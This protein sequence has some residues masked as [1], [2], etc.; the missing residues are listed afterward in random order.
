MSDLLSATKF[1]FDRGIKEI[2]LD[3]LKQTEDNIAGDPANR[4][5]ID[6]IN[7]SN[8][9][10]SH[11][12]ARSWLPGVEAAEMKATLLSGEQDKIKKLMVQAGVI[13]NSEVEYFEFHIDPNPK[14]L[15]PP[16]AAFLGYMVEEGRSDTV[17][18]SI[19]N[20]PYPQK[21]ESDWGLTEEQLRSWLATSPE[22]APWEP[23]EFSRWIPYTC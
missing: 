4:R 5:L 20:I 19:F 21:I 10:L 13:E 3:V 9:K 15:A 11:L 6:I 12:I 16:S 14:P 7:I 2:T 22:S 1:F 8:K 18:R 23:F 17:L